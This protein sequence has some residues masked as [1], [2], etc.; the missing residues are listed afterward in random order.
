MPGS[1]AES[2]EL[3]TYVI[4]SLPLF[5]TSLL[6]ETL[7]D[8]AADNLGDGGILKAEICWPSEKFITDMGINHRNIKTWNQCWI[9]L[10]WNIVIVATFPLLSVIIMCIGMSQMMGSDTTQ[11]VTTQNNCRLQLFA[12]LNIITCPVQH[13]WNGNSHSYS[14]KNYV[15]VLLC[16]I[17]DNCYR[18]KQ[19]HEWELLSPTTSQLQALLY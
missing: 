13:G 14:W 5:L 17:W 12:K 2:F 15:F 9:C 10:E 6:H 16:V 7:L 1:P 18:N 19:T 8:A 3:R 4:T 11:C